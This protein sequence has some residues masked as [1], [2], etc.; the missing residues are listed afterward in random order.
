MG[1]RGVEKYIFCRLFCA[2]MIPK[3]DR[4]EENTWTE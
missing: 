3:T 4:M 2:G 1:G